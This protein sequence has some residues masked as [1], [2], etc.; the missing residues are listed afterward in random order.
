MF[1]SRGILNDIEGRGNKSR[2][3]M[4]VEGLIFFTK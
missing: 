2:N 3:E 4:V 1:H